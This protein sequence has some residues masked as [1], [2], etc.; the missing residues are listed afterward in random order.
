MRNYVL[1]SVML[2]VRWKWVSK[3]GEHLHF[4]EPI[5]TTPPPPCNTTKALQKFMKWRTFWR[6]AQGPWQYVFSGHVTTCILYRI[7]GRNKIHDGS[8]E[9]MRVA[10]FLSTCHQSSLMISSE[11]FPK[12]LMKTAFSNFLQKKKPPELWLKHMENVGKVK[13][14][15]LL[16]FKNTVR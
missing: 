11:E 16:P 4:W 15:I 8:T 14:Y 3:A 5:L 12:W 7:T 10:C 13:Q 1:L 6:A 2:L 9:I